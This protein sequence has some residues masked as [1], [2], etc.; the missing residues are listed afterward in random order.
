MSE[1]LCIG[2]GDAFGSGGR[3]QSAYL[4]RSGA[5]GVL[6]D[7]GQTTNSGL[8]AL[9][10]SREEI[11]VILISHFHADHFGGLPLLLIA[12]H[13]EDARRAPLRI[14]GPPG[15]EARVR[16]LAQAQG[17]P[18]EKH[19]FRFPLHFEELPLSSEREIGPV[20][21]RAFPTHHAPASLPHGLALR[22][23]ALRVAYS[24]DTGWF[25]GLPA[26]V[27]S[28]DLF[29]CECT[30]EKP[31]FEY[32][33]SLAELAQHR[34]AFHCGRWLLTHLGQAMRARHSFE[35]FEAADDGLRLAL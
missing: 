14:A 32:H 29:L 18:L 24:G 5:G 6:L 3:R 8:S 4:L 9:G 25:D 19:A 12:A 17:H 35:G 23:A 30:F 33:L 28:S 21:V 31:T 20:Q 2:T 22:A 15:I 1:L 27:G 11:E 13:Y 10:V 34:P 26:Q 16:E 7:C